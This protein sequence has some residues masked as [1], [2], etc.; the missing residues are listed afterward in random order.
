MGKVFKLPVE[1]VGCFTLAM[2]LEHVTVSFLDACA[3]NIL[4]LIVVC[5][6]NGNLSLTHSITT[7][8]IIANNCIL[9]TPPRAINQ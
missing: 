5:V 3:Y 8:P 7:V 4:I 9:Y 2:Q 1:V 6:E